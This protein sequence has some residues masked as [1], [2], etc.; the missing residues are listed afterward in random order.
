MVDRR[1]PNAPDPVAAKVENHRQWRIDLGAAALSASHQIAR[2]L[3]AR[4]NRGRTVAIAMSLDRVP[5][6]SG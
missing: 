6:S 5:W 4:S 3:N 2:S 1:T